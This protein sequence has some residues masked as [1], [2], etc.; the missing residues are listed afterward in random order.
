MLLLLNIIKVFLLQAFFV[1]Y[2]YARYPF[3]S[4]QFIT[5][6]KTVA[7]LCGSFTWI[8]LSP[9]KNNCDKT[10]NPFRSYPGINSTVSEVE[11][12]H[13]DS[14][15]ELLS[16]NVGKGY[17]FEGTFDQQT[18]HDFNILC[19]DKKCDD[20]I[21]EVNLDE[22]WKRIK[23]RNTTRYDCRE[24]YSNDTRD[25]SSCPF[26]SR[27]DIQHYV[28]R[29]EMKHRRK[30]NEDPNEKTCIDR[31][32]RKY[33]PPE[34]L[35]GKCVMLQHEFEKDGNF[36]TEFFM[37]VEKRD[38]VQRIAQYS[39][40]HEIR[41][42][43][44]IIERL[45]PK[46]YSKEADET[47]C[48]ALLMN[49]EAF[50]H[51]IYD[52]KDSEMFHPKNQSFFY[53]PKNEQINKTFVQTGVELKLLD[54]EKQMFYVFRNISEGRF[55][56]SEFCYISTEFIPTVVSNDI[57]IEFNVN[58]RGSNMSLCHENSIVRNNNVKEYLRTIKGSIEDYCPWENDTSYTICFETES[59]H[60]FSAYVEAL[61]T[62]TGAFNFSS[63]YYQVN[64]GNDCYYSIDFE[65]GTK[66]RISPKWISSIEDG[67]LNATKKDFKNTTGCGT[68]F[69]TKEMKQYCYEK[70]RGTM[71]EYS[72]SSNVIICKCDT[73]VCDE[74]GVVERAELDSYK[75][76]VVCNRG[77]DETSSPSPFFFCSVRLKIVHEN[78]KKVK[79]FNYSVL[80]PNDEYNVS[81][82]DCWNYQSLYEKL[83]DREVITREIKSCFHDEMTKT[84]ECCCYTSE[85][86]C[87]T[88]TIVEKYFEVATQDTVE[89][90]N[91]INN[92]CAF[93]TQI[94]AT[95][96]ETCKNNFVRNDDE[97]RCY[98]IFKISTTGNNN[99]AKPILETENCYWPHPQYHDKYSIFCSNQFFDIDVLVDKNC[100]SLFIHDFTSNSM[101]RTLILC[102]NAGLYPEKRELILSRSVVLL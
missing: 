2:V 98:G 36:I 22:V 86:A 57:N 41:N 95:T 52:P 87:N 48:M 33:P 58:F 59:E 28:F 62:V 13:K 100:L 8:P 43:H 51:C 39:H 90:S 18:L 46:N 77:S 76:A 34:G 60:H 83:V 31:Y 80:N 64:A 25:N 92:G 79:K 82:S 45:L 74:P 93:K 26:S 72:K 91:R 5:Y 19:S 32:G 81:I 15:K 17:K 6:N 69:I 61:N 14:C 78:E 99:R 11:D 47:N 67:T 89:V 70:S 23:D 88:Q 44:S 101:Q 38:L 96:D 63:C 16:L 24:T 65:T 42:N 85:T 53:C 27:I 37:P 49:K 102:C 7:Q 35:G 54:Y 40:T 55:D 50:V 94:S 21:P 84:Y 10:S 73:P 1:S 66:T 75:N 20:L 71:K 97:M 56:F 29:N 30:I 12:N 9:P 68:V 3:I 4:S